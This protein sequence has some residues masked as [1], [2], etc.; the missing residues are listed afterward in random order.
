MGQWLERFEPHPRGAAGRGPRAAMPDHRL[1]TPNR[2]E[3]LP[4]ISGEQ[5]VETVTEADVREILEDDDDETDAPVARRGKKPKPRIVYGSGE[6]S[7]RFFS[8]TPERK[9]R[10]VSTASC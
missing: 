3:F 8:N 5:V 9:L 2:R 4:S 1:R 7:P 6:A 10:S